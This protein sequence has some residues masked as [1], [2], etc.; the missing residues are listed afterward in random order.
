[1]TQQEIY[2]TC[3]RAIRSLDSKELKVAFDA[4]Q[5][6]ISGTQI[7]DFQDR[8]DEIQET[9]KNMLRYRAE[10][11]KDPM[12]DHI[13]RSIQTQA[14][15]L[16]DHIQRLLLRRES[17]LTYYI[18]LRNQPVAFKS[19]SEQRQ[20]IR[21]KVDLDN[22]PGYEQELEDLFMR[23]WLSDAL[24]FSDTEEIKD[25]VMDLS[26][27]YPVG[28]QI[29][30]ALTLGLQN[31]FDVNKVMLLFDAATHPE[32]EIRIRAYIG[33]LITLYL[34]RKRITL[35]PSIYDR[36]A[37]LS[38]DKRFV[39][40]IRTI[41]LRF[42]LARETEKI[43]RKLQDEI[44]PE[45][46][47]FNSRIN[48]KTDLSN[49][50]PEQLSEGMNPEW[51]TTI[52]NPEFSKKIEEF[53]ELQQE[54]ADVMH[55]SFIHLK[56]F[57]FFSKV[58]NWFLPFMEEL[59]SFKNLSEEKNTNPILTMLKE[60]P[61]MCNSDKY[62][63]Y[64]SVM[65]LSVRHRTLMVGQV[66]SQAE[67][68]LK[69]TKDDLPGN[70]D[71]LIANQYIQDLYRF[72][73]VYP[74]HMDFD[75]IFTFPLDFHNLEILK[76]YLSD[77]ET[78]TIIAEYYLRKNYFRDALVIYHRLAEGQHDNPI[79]FQKTGYCHQMLGE[80]EQALDDYLHADLI[81]Q[82]KWTIRRIAFCYKALKQPEEALSY[83]NKY[84]Q[85][86]PDNLTILNSIGHCLLEL[87]QYN[88]AL[89]YFF[90][91][92][93]LDS[94]N[95]K[96]WR[97]IA[98]CS[99]LIGKYDQARNYYKKILTDQPTAQDFLNAGHTEWALQNINGAL[100]LYKQAVHKESGNM[101][102]FMEMFYEDMDDLLVAGIEEE[103]FPLMLDQ[104]SYSL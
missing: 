92:D 3:Q 40:T 19:Y 21:I 6:L 48:K 1:M 78:L 90:K 30:S 97:P 42:I 75:D 58:P 39:S 51:M 104:L 41:T 47:K 37:L 70:T 67:E 17:T 23:I 56:S 63:L 101:N 65:Q 10:G 49:F 7:F 96:A 46:V 57:S 22:R 24:N 38:E 4:L 62:S 79:L 74:A 35:Y 16:T 15:E 61:F 28:C 44:I 99:F 77:E 60:A 73:K 36:L 43:T 83:F 5:S 71:S 87:K 88:D 29:V 34:N 84:N 95:H 66:G 26:L 55:S 33:L 59:S 50:T 81:Q 54:G 98:W 27:P 64:F 11:V 31:F 52:E 94:E 18:Q 8:L 85:L 9:Y 82:D 80:L 13:Y 86:E 76:P 12:Q 14:Y 25:M 20:Q 32:N 102:R 91:V 93:Y 103:E 89:K 53:S 2:R 45:I 72:Y 68:F 100:T 69:Q